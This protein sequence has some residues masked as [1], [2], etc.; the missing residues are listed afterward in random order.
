ME[1]GGV[2]AT[3]AKENG[4]IHQAAV[5]KARPLPVQA[6]GAR[7]CQGGRGPGERAIEPARERQA[8]V[9]EKL[10]AK[11]DQRQIAGRRGAGNGEAGTR[12]G[13]EGGGQGR[14]VD[15]VMRVGQARIPV[16][17]PEIPGTY[18][19]YLGLYDLA[20][21]ERLPVDAPDNRLPIGQITVE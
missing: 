20:T 6:D 21:A 9:E 15:P 7:T 17:L 4:R 19:I 16:Q 8:G 13:L 1:G 14:V 2:E 11:G 18:P 5:R 12:Q 3:Q 10:G